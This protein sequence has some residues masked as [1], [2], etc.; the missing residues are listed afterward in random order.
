MAQAHLKSNIKIKN[1]RA[2]FEYFLIDKYIAGLVLT[3][4]EIK[5][6]R[7]GK[8]NIND[9][10]CVFQE[11][12]LWVRNVHISEYYLGTHYNHEPKRDRKLLLNKKELNKLLNKLKVQ[13]HTI[14][15]ILLFINESGKAKL[16]ISLAKG[17]KLYDKRETLKEKDL[18]REAERH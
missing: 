14:V 3:G 18:K 6:I 8:V 7:E 11:G 13:G 1:K 2:D 16:E 12:E 10:Y 17:K 5:S 15:P 9:A 4:S